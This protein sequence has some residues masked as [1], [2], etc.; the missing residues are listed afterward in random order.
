[1]AEVDLVDLRQEL[2][3]LRTR[4]SVAGTDAMARWE[5]WIEDPD[6][7]PS[8]ENLAH[9]LALRGGDRRDLQ[10]RLMQV[11]LSSMGRAESRVMPTLDAVL[12]LL[13]ALTEGRQLTAFPSAG[14]FTGRQRITARAE[15]LMGPLSPH[16]SVRL[17]VTLPTE[18]ADDPYFTLRL[19]EM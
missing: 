16:S 13:A 17:M 9:Y 14:F 8:A 10:L 19:A 12:T 4:V 3:A 7:R 6:Y 5:G 2:E 1:M 11:G 18:A 15:R